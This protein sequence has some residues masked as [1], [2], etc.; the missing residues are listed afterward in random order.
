MMLFS[1]YAMRV[2]DN[3]AAL[4]TQPLFILCAVLL[5]VVICAVLILPLWFGR[6]AAVEGDRQAANLAI[7]RDQ[8][9]DLER[10]HQEGIL[11]EVDFAQARQEL[12]RRLLDEAAPAEAAP[13]TAVPSRKTAIALGLLLPLGALLGYLLLGTPAA[14]DPARTTPAQGGMTQEQVDGMVAR[15]AERMQ[16]HPDDVQGWLLLARSYEALGRRDDAAKAGAS[17]EQAVARLAERAQAKPDDMP[18][19]LLLARSYELLGRYDDAAKVYA[20]AE[21]AIN[22]QPDLLARYAESLA[23]SSGQNGLLA[24]KPRQLVERALKLDPQHAYSLYLAAAAA[25]QA[26]EKEKAIAYWE[27]L[28]PQLEPGSEQAQMVRASIDKL[29]GK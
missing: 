11:A 6:R 21:K 3:F 24:G 12:Q 23:L 8:L 15:L 25:T 2:R 4:F 10:E 7:F 28:L 16:S 27:T 20:K 13:A 9:A 22:D 1:V 29:K 14:L 26:N 5:V 18:G 19:Q 17:A